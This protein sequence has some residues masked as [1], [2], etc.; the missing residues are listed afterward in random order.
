MNKVIKMIALLACMAMLMGSAVISY[1]SDVSVEATEGV[2]FREN[3]ASYT[4]Q[5]VALDSEAT[6]YSEKDTSSAVVMNFAAGDT[7]YV[8]GEDSEWFEIFYK[9]ETMYISRGAVSDEAYQQSQAQAQ[10]LAEQVTE[11]LE[12]QEKQAE[13]FA[14]TFEKYK[15]GQKNAMIWKIIIGVLVVAI[16]AISVVAALK[17]N[18]NGDKGSKNKESDDDIEDLD[19]EYEDEPEDDYQEDYEDES[20]EGSDDKETD[21]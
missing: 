1:A 6:A 4:G 5:V 14:E 3:G 11:E 17:N 10:E 2:S 16:I 8:T 19:E 20:E 21:K 15:R 13:A 12:V 18:K 7:V 9:G